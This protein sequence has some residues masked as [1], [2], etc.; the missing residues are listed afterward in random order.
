MSR[1]AMVTFALMLVVSA[2]GCNN[3]KF[4]P[5]PTEAE[6][7][8][9][10]FSVP[11][12]SDLFITY[13][14]LNE[15]AL[16]AGGAP[17]ASITNT[18]IIPS[19]TDASDTGDVL[20]AQGFLDGFS[21]TMPMQIDFT[22]NIDPTSVVAGETVRVFEISILPPTDAMAAIGL[23][24]SLPVGPTSGAPGII[25]ELQ[26]D[27]DYSVTL[28]KSVQYQVMVKPKVPWPASDNVTLGGLSRGILVMVT[29]GV[30]DFRGNAVIR[31]DQYARMAAGIP[32]NTGNAATDGFANAIGAAVQSSLGLLAAQA[33]V[34]PDSVVVT[35]YFTCQ[36][37][38]DVLDAGVAAT[39]A[40]APAATTPG[41]AISGVDTVGDFLTLVGA[42]NS[43][44]DLP[45]NANLAQGTITL[46]TFYPGDSSGPAGWEDAVTGYWTDGNKVYQS[47]SAAPNDSFPTRYSPIAVPQ[48]PPHEVPVLVMTPNHV[49]GPY[50]VVIFQHGITRSRFDGAAFSV[51]LCTAGFA[52]V[53]MDAPLHGTTEG[54]PYWA[55]H[56]SSAP[57]QAGEERTLGIDRVGNNSGSFIDANMDGIADLDE[58]GYPVGDMVPDPSGAY[59]LNF[60]SLISSRSVWMQAVCDLAMLTETLPTW[61]FDGDP[62]T[63]IN[64]ADFTDEV[65]YVGMSLG[66]LIG[67]TFISAMAPGRVTT[68]ELNVTGGGVAKMLEN[69]PVYNPRLMDFFAGEGLVQ[70]STR[71]EQAL[72]VISAIADGIDPVV[73]IRRAA[74]NSAVHMGVIKGGRPSGGMFG[75]E[76]PDTVVST[77][78]LGN[79]LYGLMVGTDA[80]LLPNGDPTCVDGRIDN[81]ADGIIQDAECV[82]KYYTGVVESSHLG[83]SFPMIRIGSLPVHNRV[84]IKNFPPDFHTGGA[85]NYNAGNHG[86]FADPTATVGALMQSEG[87][88]WAMFEG[89]L[90]NIQSAS[91]LVDPTDFS[92]DSSDPE[93]AVMSG[94]TRL[95]RITLIETGDPDSPIEASFET[96]GDAGTLGAAAAALGGHHFNWYQLITTDDDPER[97]VSGDLASTGSLLTVPRI[98]PPSGG[99]GQS[100]NFANNGIYADDKPWLWNEVQAPP[101]D[102][103]ADQ[104]ESAVDYYCVREFTNNSGAPT[105]AGIDPCVGDPA[106]QSSLV[107]NVGPWIG[108]VSTIGDRFQIRAWLVLVDENGDQV[109]L[110][111]GFTFSQQVTAGS[112]GNGISVTTTGVAQMPGSPGVTGDDTILSGF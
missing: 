68:A 103:A 31:S 112:G 23:P 107:Y 48:G 10:A 84:E 8:T 5:T 102:F 22:H 110:L 59:F 20:V 24:I 72:N 85:S 27:V 99:T 25:R 98:D 75:F 33:G 42:I 65:H 54:N 79:G 111:N 29:N 93:I 35:N 1:I 51:L 97:A 13:A 50:P 14:G 41:V 86:S 73:H 45:Y 109:R 55:G 46:P 21:N 81:I 106:V 37:V 96:V 87:V 52:V 66:G 83:G 30:R 80:S 11:F 78:S 89:K 53:S 3:S 17:G 26:A 44:A 77:N 100:A 58:N 38:T 105:P 39:L 12:P 64:G 57:G 15:G 95:G 108:N 9:G 18:P 47:A 60:P 82:T 92:L 61:D 6:F 67:T 4:T 56:G 2:A 90:R 69:S 88:G 70:G 91:V 7:S 101:G 71:A 74:A 40:Q 76:L 28:A 63:G 16:M 34:N 49:A 104:N 36:S 62:L 32:D 43:P 94:E 19:A